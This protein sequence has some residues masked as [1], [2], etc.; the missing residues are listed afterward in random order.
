MRLTIEILIERHLSELRTL[1]K[2]GGSAGSVRAG[3]ELGTGDL[4]ILFSRVKLKLNLVAR[5]R[6]SNIT[7]LTQAQ[8]PFSSD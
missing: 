1:L 4:S 5:A 8:T 2:I 6:L 3:R 7:R